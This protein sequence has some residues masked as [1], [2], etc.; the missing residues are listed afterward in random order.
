MALR[1]LALAV[2]RVGK[3]HRWGRRITT[4]T[5][6]AHVGP[7][8][9]GLGLA[10]SRSQHRRRC[11][12]RVE[13]ACG[14]HIP[15]HR[16]DQRSQ[17]TAGFAYPVR[18]RGA[19]QIEPRAF[20][21]FRLAIERQVI[22]KLRNQYVCQQA[23]SCETAID[24]TAR[25]RSLHDVR[26]AGAAQLGPDDADHFEPRRHKLEQFV[27]LRFD[28]TS[29][30]PCRGRPIARP[31]PMVT[32]TGP[33]SMRITRSRPAPNAMRMPNSRVRRVT[34]YATDPYS[35]TQANSRVIALNRLTSQANRRS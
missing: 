25:R 29:Q 7:Q 17:Q 10:R 30:G 14:Q 11:V 13:F 34:A 20:V 19:I 32:V 22:R 28:D 16:I 8:P 4:G 12:V 9:T 23:R 26:T 21:D 15:A 2:R 33:R 1:M 35:P 31:T 18:Q 5:V 6:I 3:P 27:E 24:G